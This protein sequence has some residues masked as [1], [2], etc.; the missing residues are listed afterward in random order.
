M[1]TLCLEEKS[2]SSPIHKLPFSPSMKLEGLSANPSPPRDLSMESAAFLPIAMAST[3]EV[4]P[5]AAS[6]PANTPGT[7]VSRVCGLISMF[8]SSVNCILRS[9][10]RNEKSGLCPT[11]RITVSASRNLL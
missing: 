10:G 2:F 5:E 8:P 3:A 9:G 11:A 6:P 4:G 1:E 7:L